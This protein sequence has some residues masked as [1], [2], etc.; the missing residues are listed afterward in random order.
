MVIIIIT[1]MAVII[2]KLP[3][4]NDSRSPD[5]GILNV[6]GVIVVDPEDGHEEYEQDHEDQDSP[7]RKD[8][9]GR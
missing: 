4:Q 5:N 1:G 7:R 8:T 3:Y 9:I 2:L 6:V